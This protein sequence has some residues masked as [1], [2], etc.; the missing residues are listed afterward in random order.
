M[1]FIES[2]ALKNPGFPYVRL[3][4]NNWDDYGYK[5]TFN[6]SLVL[7]G[8]QSIDL[9]TIK[10]LKSGQT[11]GA[12]PLP[13]HP[14]EKLGTDYCSVGSDAAYYETLFKLGAAIYQP[15]LDGVSDAAYSDHVRAKFEDVEGYKVSLLRFGGAERTIADASLLFATSN[16]I[17]RKKGDGFV[18]SFKTSLA[19]RANRF[20]IDFDFQTRGNLPNRMNA[21]IGY[22]G[23][24]KTR[25]LSNLAIAVSGYG[26]KSIEDSSKKRAGFFVGAPPPFRTVV[27]VSYSAFDTFEIPGATEVERARLQQEGNIFGYVYCGLREHADSDDSSSGQKEPTYRLRTPKETDAEFLTAVRRVRESHRSHLLLEILRPILSDASFQRIGLTSLYSSSGGGDDEVLMSLFRGLSSGHKVVLKILTEMTAQL[28]DSEPAL[29]LIDEPETHLHP[30]LLAAFLK[31]VRTCLAHFDAYAIVSTHSP[32]VLQ[33]TP[34]PY[35]RVLRRV[36]S[37][38]RV[39]NPTTET[40]G[41]NIGVITSDVFNLDDGSTD[42]HSTLQSLAQEFSL[43]EIEELFQHRLGFAAKSYVESLREEG[44][45]E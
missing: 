42:W 44:E 36:G 41:E 24:G 5:T 20:V 19:D 38:S 10:I 34:S 29:V 6:S 8:D 15:Y 43:K 14:V 7:S 27:V 1:W 28:D 3:T 31:S 40:F 13:D 21:L 39:D 45:R 22:N 2:S 33:E 37:Q 32:V 16:P 25:L 4:W 9:G 35:V 18:F 17:T 23:T 26:Y 12:T 30:P 11:S